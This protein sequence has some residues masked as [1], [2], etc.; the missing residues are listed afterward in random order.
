M[1]Q[2]PINVLQGTAAEPRPNLV[3][4]AECPALAA[5]PGALGLR[6]NHA[7]WSASTH[8]HPLGESAGANI[9]GNV[10]ALQAQSAL[11]NLLDALPSETPSRPTLSQFLT[12]DTATLLLMVN[13]LLQEVYAKNA[14]ILCQQIQRASDVQE[15]LRDKQLKDYQAQINKAAEQADKVC[16]A[17]IFSAVCDWIISGVQ[18]AVGALRIMAGDVVGGTATIL[19]G[20]AGILKASAETALLCGADKEVCSKIILAAT[21]L[22]TLFGAIAMIGGMSVA[23]NAKGIGQAMGGSKYITYLS[24]GNEGIGSV[25][26]IQQS[27]TSMAV[28][29]LQHQ[30]EKLMADQS[31]NGGVQRWVETRKS[32]QYQQLRDTFQD[33]I[34]ARKSTLHIMDNYGT[35][36]AQ[37]VSGRA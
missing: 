37:V 24:A 22:Q 25:N 12:L 11:D 27:G 26:Q 4:V 20:V 34:Q 17:G 31:F 10:T 29:D 28:A 33:S 8:T 13:G 1:S 16:K 15:V 9:T 2:Y 18:L 14:D 30:I 6:V 32:A 35:A 36:L 7:A 23:A 21:V 19:N 5:T 3:D